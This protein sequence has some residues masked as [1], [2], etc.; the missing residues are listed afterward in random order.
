MP[1]RRASR[2]TSRRR[3]PGGG[4]RTRSR[5]RTSTCS[6]SPRRPP[7]RCVRATGPPLAMACHSS[8]GP[9]RD[10]Y[11]CCADNKLA[12][13][14]PGRQVSAYGESAPEPGLHA[15]CLQYQIVQQ[16][17]QMDYHDSQADFV[18]SGKR[19]RRTLRLCM[20]RCLQRHRGIRP[21]SLFRPLMPVVSR[22]ESALLPHAVH[23]PCSI[24]KRDTT[25]IP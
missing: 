6:A 2:I 22:P 13:S 24:R 3:T 18:P 8:T 9:G 12:P 5:V 19:V 7:K 20:Q 17:A 4:A 25:H 23:A 21:L 16:A 14:R 1:P 15:S 10:I 11:W